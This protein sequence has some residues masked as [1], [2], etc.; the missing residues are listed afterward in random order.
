[1]AELDLIGATD[2]EIETTLHGYL[3]A[4]NHL[5]MANNAFRAFRAWR[6]E[7]RVRVLGQ[8]TSIVSER[9]QYGGTPDL[10]AIINN[11]IGI[12]DFKTSLRAKSTTT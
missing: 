10:I 9:C 3:S 1:M 6:E 5:E 2:R 12:L 11:T 8:E 7:N 4:P